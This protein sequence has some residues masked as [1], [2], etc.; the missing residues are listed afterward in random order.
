M[1]G[2]QEAGL[3]RKGQ[4]PNT[5]ALG[6]HHVQLMPVLGQRLH[7][8]LKAQ[9][10]HGNAAFHRLHLLL[11][12]AGRGI[13]CPCHLGQQRLLMKATNIAHFCRHKGDGA[14]VILG[15]FQHQVHHHI[16]PVRLCHEDRIHQGM[17]EDLAMGIATHIIHQ[18]LAIGGRG[19]GAEDESTHRTPD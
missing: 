8:L 2:K 16:R 17:G 6:V 13:Q 15:A 5:L 12:H 11:A 19:A 1:I 7:Q 14:G 18:G 10:A 9:C 3:F 4:L